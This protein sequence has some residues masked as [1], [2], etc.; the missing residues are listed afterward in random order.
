MRKQASDFPRWILLSWRSRGWPADGR[1]R[2]L[3]RTADVLN[4]RGLKVAVAPVEMAEQRLLKVDE[5][6]L[7][8]GLD[9]MGKEEL[10]VAV[11]SDRELPGAELEQL[12]REFP[13]F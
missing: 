9:E 10:V 11:E 2:I 8:S 4:M 12:T 6:C 5:V 3:G 1:V 7:F 13:S